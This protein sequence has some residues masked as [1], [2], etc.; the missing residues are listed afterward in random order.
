MA[1]GASLT[2]MK[3]RKSFPVRALHPAGWTALLIGMALPVSAAVPVRLTLN[4]GQD[5]NPVWDPASG[6][7]AYMRS[8]AA[9]GSGVPFNLYRVQADGSG[10]GVM[11]TGPTSGFGLANSPSWIGSTGFLGLEERAVFHEYLRF[12]ASMAPFTRTVTDGNDAAFT[13]LLSITG[14]GGG[15]WIRFSRDG[16]TAM[17]RWSTSGGSGT[18]QVRTGPVSSLTGQAA[19]SAGT[20]VV[21]T[22]HATQQRM[23]TPGAISPDGSLAILS[24]PWSGPDGNNTDARD[25]WLYRLDGSGPALNLTQEGVSGAFSDF[26]EFIPGTGRILYARYSGVQGET[27]DLYEIGVDGS[28]KRQIT[29]TPHFA[30]YAPSLSPTGDRVAFVGGHIAGFEHTEPALPEGEVANS[31]IYMM[32]MEGGDPGE[33]TLDIHRAVELVW[34]AESGVR[35]Q[36][37]YSDDGVT[38]ENLGEAVEGEGGVVSVFQPARD[39]AHRLYRLQTVP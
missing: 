38:W 32:A 4:P 19:G 7:I 17:W 15:G 6:T 21:Q 14:G 11:A 3:T 16:Q 13:R 39:P 34:Q 37:Q 5:I 35:Y 31:N 20:L 1:R 22:V 30:E 24:L 23:T 28:G 2:T 26:A 29:D 9:S 18:Q 27:W 10:E 8:A 33:L 12:D 36:V 25:L